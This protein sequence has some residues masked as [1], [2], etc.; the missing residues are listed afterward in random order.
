MNILQL[1]PCIPV[2]T[3]KGEGMAIGWMDYSCEHHLMW[4]VA[5]NDTGEVWTLPNPDVRL[6]KN[7]SI[8]RIIG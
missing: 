4:I 5:M 8:G 3:E 6:Q 7:Y 2:W 1:N